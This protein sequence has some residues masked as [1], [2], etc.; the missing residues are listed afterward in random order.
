[1]ST[2]ACPWRGPTLDRGARA[3]RAL[4]YFLNLDLRKVGRAR[5][6]VIVVR[7]DGL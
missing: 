3:A 5:A 6:S 4:Q 1:V 7:C 2:A